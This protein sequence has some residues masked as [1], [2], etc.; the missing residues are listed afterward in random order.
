MDPQWARDV[1]AECVGRGVAVFGKQWG[2]WASNPLV[3][4]GRDLGDVRRR[5]PHG[6]GGALLDGELWREFP[7]IF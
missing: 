3:R 7:A 2:S 1:T 4:E 6:K 5:D